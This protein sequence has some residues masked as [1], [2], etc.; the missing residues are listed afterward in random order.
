MPDYQPTGGELDPRQLLGTVRA[1]LLTRSDIGEVVGLLNRALASDV[2]EGRFATLLL[3]RLDPR[4]RSFSYVSAGHPSGYILHPDGTVKASLPSTSMPLA[5]VADATFAAD[6]PVTLEP[7]E[8]VLLLTDGILEA[9]TFDD[10]LFG[11]GRT[12]EVVRANWN[13]PARQIIDSLYG[14]VRDFCGVTTQ[15]DDMTAIVIKVGSSLGA[16]APG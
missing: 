1:F 9:H 14:A 16:D 10:T 3:A 2:P 6:P 12:L 15:L 11:V 5:I 8:G 7:G 13:R 4:T